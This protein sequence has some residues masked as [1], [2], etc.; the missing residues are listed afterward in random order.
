MASAFF[1]LGSPAKF[2]INLYATQRSIDAN[3]WPYGQDDY[4]SEADSVLVLRPHA[5]PDDGR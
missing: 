4:P 3:C 2:V 1:L 5:L